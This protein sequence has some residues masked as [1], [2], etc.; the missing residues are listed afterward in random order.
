MTCRL[1]RARAQTFLAPTLA[2]VRKFDGVVRFKKT[3]ERLVADSA[4]KRNG[5]VVHVEPGTGFPAKSLK[6]HSGRVDISV[7]LW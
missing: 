7:D 3:R 6:K 1:L 5:A 2:Y 4:K